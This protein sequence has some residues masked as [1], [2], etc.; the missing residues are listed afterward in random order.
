MI[1]PSLPSSPPTPAFSFSVYISW[2]LFVLLFLFLLAGE[3]CTHLGSGSYPDRGSVAYD[4]HQNALPT[5]LPIAGANRQ[6]PCPTYLPIPR[7]RSEAKKYPLALC[8]YPLVSAGVPAAGDSPGMAPFRLT[9]G[10][11]PAQAKRFFSSTP[12][13]TYL[14]IAGPSGAVKTGPTYLLHRV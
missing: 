2:F 4:S 11:S 13:A 3:R 14:P 12:T 1:G 7:P 5:D 8:E 10:P 6:A 9:R